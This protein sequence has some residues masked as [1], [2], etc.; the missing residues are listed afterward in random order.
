MGD[1]PPDLFHL[2]SPL[3]PEEVPAIKKHSQELADDLEREIEESF[4]KGV[5]HGAKLIGAIEVPAQPVDTSLQAA[6]KIA[7]RTNRLR[8]A[9]FLYLKTQGARGATAGELEQALALSGSTVR[10]RLRELEGTAPWCHGKLP[11]RIRRTA[12]KRDGMRVY[13]V[14]A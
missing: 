8:E 11:V 3:H 14:L 9:I 2:D 7:G 4:Q 10:P 12:E 6:A 13:Q 5:A 1:P